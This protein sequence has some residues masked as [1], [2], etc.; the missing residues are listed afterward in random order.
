MINYFSLTTYRNLNIQ[1]QY[2]CKIIITLDFLY[3]KHAILLAL[4]VGQTG[5][6]LHVNKLEHFPQQI[7][8]S[9][10]N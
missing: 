2:I 7:Q 4:I 3:L 1:L 5:C 8:L 10:H 6:V 9:V